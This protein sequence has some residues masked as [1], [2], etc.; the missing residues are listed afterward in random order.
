VVRPAQDLGPEPRMRPGPPA[1]GQLLLVCG[2]SAAGKT[3]FIRQLQRDRLPA[4]VKSFL[5]EGAQGWPQ[6]SAK[7]YVRGT[8]YAGLPRGGAS[9]P[10]LIF[11]YDTMRVNYLGF[12]DYEADPALEILGS[13][14]A[15][16]LVDLRPTPET[17]GQHVLWRRERRQRNRWVKKL[18]HLGKRARRPE[19]S[20]A[21]AIPNSILVEDDCLQ[22]GWIERQYARWDAYLRTVPLREVIRLEPVLRSRGEPSFRI[23]L[24][25]LS[26][27]HQRSPSCCSP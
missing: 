26:S 7:E 24:P 8:G 21:P 23:A 15:I 10:A 13:A 3:T 18:V 4:A 11:H 12:A 2:P 1:I 6:S 25:E 16:V 14:E 27:S 17:L 9:I 19:L 5:P 22:P 20:S